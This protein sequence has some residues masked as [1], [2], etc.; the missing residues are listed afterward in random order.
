VVWV[1]GQAEQVQAGK[2]FLV[3]TKFIELLAILL[4]QVSHI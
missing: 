2:L 3:S 1:Q 4:T